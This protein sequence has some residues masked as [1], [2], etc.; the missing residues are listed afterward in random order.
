MEYRSVIRK[1]FAR[2]PKARKVTYGDQFFTEAWF[3][4]WQELAPVLRALIATQPSWRAILDYGCGPGAMID[5]M[6]AAGWRYVGCDRSQEARSLYLER[7][8]TNPQC[9][10]SDLDVALNAGFDVLLSFDVLEHL[11]DDEVRILLRATARIPEVFVNI[12]RARKIP[13]HINLKN[14]ERWVALF[15]QEGLK[16]HHERTETLRQRYVQLRPKRQD[17]WDRNM[18]VFFREARR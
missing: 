4:G 8:G 15:A 1:L 12:S 17:M 5:L 13:G 16:L 14:D 18:F 2:F 11:T 10:E 6:N 7:F 3:D 9:Y